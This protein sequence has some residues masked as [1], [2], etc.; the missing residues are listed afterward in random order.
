M[1]ANSVIFSSNYDKSYATNNILRTY[2]LEYDDGQLEDRLDY[3]DWRLT[4]ILR[5]I[6]SVTSAKYNGVRKFTTICYLLYGNTT[7]YRLV[8]MYNGYMHP[9]EIPQ[10]AILLFPDPTDLLNAVTKTTT[11]QS[12]AVRSVIF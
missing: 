5:Q 7:I 11:A 2:E 8:L 3:S 9:Y 10:G 6:T 1:D 12:K 4:R